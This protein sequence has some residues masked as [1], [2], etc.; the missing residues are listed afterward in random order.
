MPTLLAGLANV[1]VFNIP[2]PPGAGILWLWRL[3][4]VAMPLFAGAVV[5]DG[6]VW[7]TAL[8]MTIP[9]L[10]APTYHGALILPL[11]LGFL[12]PFLW[13]YFVQNFGPVYIVYAAF[14]LFGMK[15]G[16]AVARF[17]KQPLGTGG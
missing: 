14:V 5:A 2:H 1:I 13:I 10:M 17:R 7:F 12:H 9:A 8:C 4:L 16:K 15:T 3:T 6:L 11:I